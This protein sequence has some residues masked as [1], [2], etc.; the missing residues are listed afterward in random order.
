DTGFNQS[1]QAA[2]RELQVAAPPAAPPT[3]G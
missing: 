3:G 2:V 1:V